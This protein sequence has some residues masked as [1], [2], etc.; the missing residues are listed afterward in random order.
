M[1][2]PAGPLERNSTSQRQHPWPEL[3]A[4]RAGGGHLHETPAGPDQRQCGGRRGGRGEGGQGGPR[5]GQRSTELQPLP[6][7]GHHQHGLSQAGR[8][9]GGAGAGP[10]QGG[11]GA[12]RQG[13]PAEQGR[14]DQAR[15][16]AAGG[17]R[18]QVAVL[19]FL[20][21]H[22]RLHAPLPR[23]PALQSQGKVFLRINTAETKERA[24]QEPSD[25]IV[26]G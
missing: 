24:L 12:P 5:Q 10:D 20:L 21:H 23:H 25:A 15:V 22:H 26:D 17:D 11:E 9:G 3:P 7:A 1:H 6:Q 19:V 2:C 18:G 16:E 8:E 14:S 4:G 13:E